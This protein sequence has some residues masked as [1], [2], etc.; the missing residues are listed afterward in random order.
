MSPANHNVSFNIGFFTSLL[1]AMPS[2]LD[3]ITHNLGFRRSNNNFRVST[4]F[5]EGIGIQ[6]LS[7]TDI[8]VLMKFLILTTIGLSVIFTGI[9][10]RRFIKKY[11]NI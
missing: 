7:L 8:P 2:I 10:G 3:W 9:F 1:L 6:L 4:G 5:L 11:S